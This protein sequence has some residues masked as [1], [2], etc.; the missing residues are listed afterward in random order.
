MNS[1]FSR[2]QRFLQKALPS[3]S[4]LLGLPFRPY[5]LL[6]PRPLLLHLQP[7]PLT[8]RQVLPVKLL[9]A[10]NAQPRVV[11]PDPSRQCLLQPVRI[12]QVKISRLLRPLV[13][14][15][16]AVLFTIQQMAQ[17]LLLVLFPIHDLILAPLFLGKFSLALLLRLQ[18][19]V[20]FLQLLL[21]RRRVDL[22]KRTTF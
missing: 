18:L 19:F 15:P 5:L 1:L 6:Q 14:T 10:R 22:G 8:L 9:C 16:K 21:Q 11:I 3:D 4:I 20:L 13:Q 12:E 17:L 2:F 7:A